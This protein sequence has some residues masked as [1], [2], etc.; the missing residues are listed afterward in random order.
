[1]FSVHLKFAFFSYFVLIFCML[2]L[3]FF[4]CFLFF[5]LEFLLSFPTLYR[6]TVVLSVTGG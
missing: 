1:M 6:Q 5:S 3:L 2:L 4:F